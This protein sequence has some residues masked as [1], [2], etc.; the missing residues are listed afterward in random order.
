MGEAHEEEEESR[1]G[2]IKEE[3]KWEGKNTSNEHLGVRG[4]GR[5]RKRKVKRGEIEGE[6]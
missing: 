2:Q 1:M 5:A 4:S 6:R 3:L